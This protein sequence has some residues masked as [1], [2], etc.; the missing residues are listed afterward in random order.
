MPN[1]Y[2]LELDIAKASASQSFHAN[3]SLRQT[4][5]S[6]PADVIVHRHSDRS[7]S[8]R[9]EG[10]LWRQAEIMGPQIQILHTRGFAEIP[11]NRKVSYRKQRFAVF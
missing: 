5:E 6:R 1:S 8:I 9:C 11:A 10:S 3:A 2:H 7:C 4:L